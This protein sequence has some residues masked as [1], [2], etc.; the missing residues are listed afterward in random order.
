MASGRE[1]LEYV[2]EQLA[3]ADG[4][5]YKA[6]MGEFVLYL[7]GT[8]VGGIYDDRLLVKPTA[9]ARRLMPD[10]SEEIPYP[11]AKPMLLV[12]CVDDRDAL[13]ELVC[14]VADDLPAPKK[15]R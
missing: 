2:L 7:H 14:A 12:G 15:K 10:A 5:S 6:M 11:G 1:Y 9:S 8:I 13:R 3:P 4:I